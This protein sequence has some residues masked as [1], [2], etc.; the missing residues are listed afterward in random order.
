MFLALSTCV[1]FISLMQSVNG[2]QILK[3][4]FLLP[5]FTAADAT[6]MFGFVIVPLKST[7]ASL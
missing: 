7:Y 3:I 1:L 4:T 6:V 2:A 5:L